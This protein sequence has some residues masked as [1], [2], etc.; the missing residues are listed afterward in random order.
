MENYKKILFEEMVVKS[1]M[2]VS[3]CDYNLHP[4]E[5]Y[6]IKTWIIDRVDTYPTSIQ[7]EVKDRLNAYI[8]EVYI[9]LSNNEVDM[10][11]IL[12]GVEIVSNLKDRLE[13]FQVCLDVASADG[14]VQ[15]VELILIHKIIEYLKLDASVARSLIEKELPIS[16]HVDLNENLVLGISSTMLDE[17]IQELLRV[18]YRKWNA[19][20]TST[21]SDIR[22]QAEQMIH[23][24]ANVKKLH[25]AKKEK[26]N[27]SNDSSVDNAVEVA[28]CSYGMI[29][30]IYDKEHNKW[31]KENRIVIK[32][33]TPL[34]HEVIEMIYITENEFRI[35]LTEGEDSDP[36]FVDKIYNEKI[37][38]P[39][40]VSGRHA[41]EITYKY[42]T[43]QIMQFRIKDLESGITKKLKLH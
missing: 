37:L 28:N 12:D 30:Y 43:N 18:Q 25:N 13:L 41:I 20:V 9:A 16:N 39:N 3:A 15:E 22:D 32:K 23:I 31:V 6:V 24:I 1:A 17:E 4:D 2:L 21:S 29:E 35:S 11:I 33:G 7:N 36:D 10:Q 19:R 38:L 40:S 8:T 34:P 27:P 26:D 14:K 5:A 42:N